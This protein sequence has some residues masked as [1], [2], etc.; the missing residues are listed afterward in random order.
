MRLLKLAPFQGTK[1]RSV[2]NKVMMMRQIAEQLGILAIL[3][4]L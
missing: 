4:N 1:E 2:L 3:M